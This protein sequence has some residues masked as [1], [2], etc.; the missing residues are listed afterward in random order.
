MV[1]LALQAV[2]QLHLQ[3]NTSDQI[4]VYWPLLINPF[5]IPP[6]NLHLINHSSRRSNQSAQRNATAARRVCVSER[7]AVRGEQQ[8]KQQLAA[9]PNARLSTICPMYHL[10][11][12]ELGERK[13]SELVPTTGEDNDYMEVF[14]EPLDTK[15]CVEF[16]VGNPRVEHITGI[17]HLYKRNTP[18]YGEAWK[19]H[20]TPEI[21][22]VGVHAA[23]GGVCGWLLHAYSRPRD[24]CERTT[25]HLSSHSFAALEHTRTHRLR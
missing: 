6:I 16:S 23:E 20:S 15:E 21:S 17:V 2:I 5:N 24:S 11:V 18:M 4:I 12:E 8:R 19:G 14:K 25:P 1:F 3:N 13:M 9:S 22:E 7:S 10:R